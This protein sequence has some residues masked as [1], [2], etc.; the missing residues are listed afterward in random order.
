MFAK[1]LRCIL[2]IAGL[3]TFLTS[4]I[5]PATAQ[6]AA[7]QS[8]VSIEQLQR[9]KLEHE[10]LE[11]RKKEKCYLCNQPLAIS[12][13]TTLTTL[14]VGG[15]LLAH[16]TER[17]AK[18][19]K[20]QEN[21]L[22]F[23][24]EVASD[25]NSVFTPLMQYIRDDALT[26][27]GRQNLLN[28]VKKKL[29]TLVQKRFSVKIKTDALLPDRMSDFAK[30]YV[31]LYQELIRIVRVIDEIEKGVY[32]T[33][34]NIE[35]IEHEQQRLTKEWPLNLGLHPWNLEQPD[36]QLSEWVEMVWVRAMDVLAAP[37]TSVL[38]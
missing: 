26:D 37:L 2:I 30:Q 4:V 7:T 14:G 36:Q 34:I 5:M 17:R 15:F 24:T 16:V 9:E 20:R 31:D 23:L 10:V 33:D 12:F 29:P 25:I 21:A 28:K 19:S 18:E 1:R 38:K 22:E 32:S 27:E 13:V 3:A 35:R 8:S 6:Q 11:L